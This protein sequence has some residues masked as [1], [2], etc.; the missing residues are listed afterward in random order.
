MIDPY[1]KIMMIDCET[2]NGIDDP[3]VYDVGYSVFNLAGEVFEEASI[4]NKDIITEPKYMASAYYADKIPDYWR[5]IYLGKRELMTWEAIKWR[6]FDA[7]KRHNVKIVAAH[8]A[9][10]DN[11]ALNL[12]Q[13]YITTSRYRWFLPY[14]IEWYDTL[15]MCRQVFKNDPAY[16]P[17]CIENGFMTPKTKQPQMTAEVIYRYITQN[18]GFTEAHTG[19]EDVRIERE[20]FKYCIERK[21]DLDGRLFPPKEEPTPD[22]YSWEAILARLLEAE[23][24]L[25][26]LLGE[27][28]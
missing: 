19:L 5:E 23:P 26:A 21:P 17:W 13:R 3:I 12:T 11:K 6:V 15:K 20:I 24:E 1:E 2:T 27:A 14:G 10:F 25:A 4:A 7:I 28:S 9:R 22:E 16:K 18:L 8:N